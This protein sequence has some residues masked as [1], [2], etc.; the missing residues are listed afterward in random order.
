MK[1]GIIKNCLNILFR[2]WAGNKHRP[3]YH[4]AFAIRKNKILAVGR[5]KPD[6]E[7]KDA[8]YLGRI[9]NIEKWNVF[10]YLHAESDLIAR[11]DPEYQ[12]HKTEI[13]S[14]RINRHG[15]FKLAKP[16]VNCQKM[17]DEIGITKIVWSCSL[18]DDVPN[19]LILKSQEKILEEKV[20]K[21]KFGD[22][23]YSVWPGKA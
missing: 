23:A 8:L 13:L 18:E 7:S 9:Y 15:R 19:D 22:K 20:E 12:N 16:C 17:L 3:N 10:P 5:N 6:Y 1:R 4:F 14:I 2:D 21:I 11:L